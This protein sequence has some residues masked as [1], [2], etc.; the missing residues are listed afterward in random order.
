M[1]TGVP[2]TLA[3]AVQTNFGIGTWGIKNRRRTVTTGTAV[4]LFMTSQVTTTLF[5]AV[6]LV[7]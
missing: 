6:L 4:I 2:T 5:A 7:A 3:V 1:R